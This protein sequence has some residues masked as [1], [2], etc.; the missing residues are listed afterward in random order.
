MGEERTLKAGESDA[1][2]I[3][4]KIFA[5]LTSIEIA[6]A[7]ARRPKEFE[8]D[9]KRPVQRLRRRLMETIGPGMS[10]VD[11]ARTLSNYLETV[12]AALADLLSSH[13]VYYWLHLS[14]RVA[15]WP[16]DGLSAHTGYLARRILHLAICKYGKPATAEAVEGEFEVVD[17]KSC[18]REVGYFD[19]V[20]IYSAEYLAYEYWHATAR[21]R[22]VCKGGT[23]KQG[24]RDYSTTTPDY[25]TRLIDLTDARAS[26]DSMF[27]VV[28]AVPFDDGAPEDSIILPLLNVGREPY[29]LDCFFSLP[30]RDPEGR[31][32][33][34]K[35]NYLPTVFQLDELTEALGPFEKEV[36]AT[37]GVS[38][39]ELA[40]ALEAIWWRIAWRL[41]DAPEYAY[42]F[43]QRG[44]FL[45]G[46]SLGTFCRDVATCFAATGRSPVEQPELERLVCG[47][48]ERFALT[49]AAQAT[50]DLWTRRSRVARLNAAE[51]VGPLLW[52]LR[53][54]QHALPSWRHL[55]S[56]VTSSGDGQ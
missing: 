46:D 23:L 54:G 10:G 11:A 3:S 49:P 7:Y 34:L 5:D 35:T 21:Y 42:E 14:R 37:T 36:V 33:R 13:S 19:S 52:S 39:V 12:E 25:L 41:S 1:P 43:L 44:W 51:E 45:Y 26:K 48:I 31:G 4:P 17:G 15:P 56:S 2:P 27:G 18:L 29:P 20:A 38:P 30:V 47:L 40:L 28:G 50:I 24:S 6:R 22:V 8:K 32:G 16:I 53:L 55:S 9:F